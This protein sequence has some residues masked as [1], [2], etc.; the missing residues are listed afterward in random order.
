M[1][2][3]RLGPYPPAYPQIWTIRAIVHDAEAEGGLALGANWIK[4]LELL[5]RVRV[6]GRLGRPT[7]GDGRTVPLHTPARKIGASCRLP[8]TL[9]TKRA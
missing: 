1:R 3:R 4:A 8:W 7:A 5:G 6:L 2:Q 9:H